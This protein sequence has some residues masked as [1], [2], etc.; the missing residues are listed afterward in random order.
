MKQNNKKG[1]A[2]AIVLCV[3]V[4]LGCYIVSLSW[5][6]AN[7]RNRYEKT[8]N[9]RKAYFMARSGIE[10]LMLKIK[11]MQR[12]CPDTMLAL[13]KAPEEE[14]NLLNSVFTGDVIIPPNKD[15]RKNDKYE[16]RINE[17]KI[18]SVDL[19]NSSLVLEMESVGKYGGYSDN[20]KRLVR[21]SR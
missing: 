4:C 6:M 13:E 1:M 15:F 20:I 5:S 18:E 19:E 3:I 9:N 7:S 11:T 12:H 10:H 2:L 17:F 16:Y 14:K 21:I 8:L